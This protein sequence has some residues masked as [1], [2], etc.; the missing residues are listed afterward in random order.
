MTWRKQKL[1]GRSI[2]KHT[3]FTYHTDIQARYVEKGS[4]RVER[5]QNNSAKGAGSGAN[6]LRYGPERAL[7]RVYSFVAIAT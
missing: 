1:H 3:P 7:V 6:V 4:F 5:T 2:A